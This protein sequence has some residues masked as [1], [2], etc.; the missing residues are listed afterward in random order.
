[1]PRKN[2]FELLHELQHLDVNPTIIFTTAYDEYA[3]KAFE[4]NSIDYLLKPIDIEKL[5]ISIEKY[6]NLKNIFPTSNLNIDFNKFLADFSINSKTYKSRFLINKGDSLLIVEID[7]IAYF[8]S[9]DKATFI[10][11]K[12]N[13]KYITNDSLDNVINTIDP[14]V[15]F[16]INRQFIISINSIAKIS[17][18][19][20]YKLKLDLIP[21]TK[22]DNTIV[23][24]TKVK[25]FKEWLSR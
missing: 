13:Q 22:N 4:I 11:T 3:L 14:S 25:E 15:F 8:Y 2:G 24:R 6:H 9:E 23:S 19:F 12:D 1:M 5:K 18:Y 16:R 20:N 21:E 10:I 7:K 17:N